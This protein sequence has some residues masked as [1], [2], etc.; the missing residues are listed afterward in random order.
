MLKS[1]LTW[2]SWTEKKFLS[3]FLPRR[4][5]KQ[6]TKTLSLPA[7]KIKE[8]GVR[9]A[10]K[11]SRGSSHPPCQ[12]THQLT[13]CRAAIKRPSTTRTPGV[14]FLQGKNDYCYHYIVT[15]ITALV[16][17]ISMYVE[18]NDKTGYSRWKEDTSL[19]LSQ[20]K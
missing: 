8:T 1:T 17:I 9:Y 2:L 12:L 18:K 19:I 10:S 6:L 4:F 14:G 7:R 3:P 20:F 13:H 15:F 5:L 11:I 16:I